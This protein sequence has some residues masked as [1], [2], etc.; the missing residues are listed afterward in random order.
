MTDQFNKEQRRNMALRRLVAT[1]NCLSL[2]AGRAAES[3][4]EHAELED[5]F[6]AWEKAVEEIRQT[7]D[8]KRY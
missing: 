6:N 8:T 3:S 7:A 2:W 1:G 5:L 4:K